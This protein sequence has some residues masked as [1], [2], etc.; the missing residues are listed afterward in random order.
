MQ[1]GLNVQS[2]PG[3]SL[4]L[5]FARKYAKIIDFLARP[6]NVWPWRA[7]PSVLFS[8]NM[9]DILRSALHAPL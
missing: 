1:P 3:S 9:L 7:V 2:A 4:D 8:R 5:R 6:A